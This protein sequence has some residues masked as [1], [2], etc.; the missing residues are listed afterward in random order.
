MGIRVIIDVS[1]P[2][3]S[4]KPAIDKLHPSPHSQQAIFHH[5]HPW[6]GCQGHETFEESLDQNKETDNLTPENIFVTLI[7]VFKEDLIKQYI[8]KVRIRW[9]LKVKTQ[10]KSFEK[11]KKRFKKYF[12]N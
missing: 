7:S 11:L 6:L 5:L 8:H 2:T 12:K 9:S 1:L 10:N 3:P 4:E